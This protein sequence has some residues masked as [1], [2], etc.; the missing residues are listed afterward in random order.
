MESLFVDPGVVYGGVTWRRDSKAFAFFANDKSPRDFHIYMFDLDT[1]Q[2]RRLMADEGLQ[3]PADFS[4]NGDRLVV[5]KYNSASYT[6]LFELDLESGN[7][8]EIT[9]KDQ[10][11]YFSPVGYSADE[12]TFLVTSNYNADLNSVREIDLRTCDIRAVLPEL[13]SCEVDYAVFND[14]RTVLAT[15]NQ[16]GRIRHASPVRHGGLRADALT[17]DGQGRGQ[18]SGVHRLA[19]AL[20]SK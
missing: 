17:A 8:R 11:W 19:A 18:Q 20:R 7:R 2:H 4:R 1:R 6:Q 3:A 12:T 15:V 14:E 5:F 13:E 16:R 9:P 10:Q